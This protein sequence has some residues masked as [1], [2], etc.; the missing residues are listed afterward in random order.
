MTTPEGRAE[1]RLY[2]AFRRMQRIC[3][4]C[5]CPNIKATRFLTNRLLQ[6]QL[7]AAS[8]DAV[9]GTAERSMPACEQ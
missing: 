7:L 3:A 8:E 4:I 9:E 5:A 1:K 2:R 6:Y